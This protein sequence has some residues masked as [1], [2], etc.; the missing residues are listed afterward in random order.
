MLPLVATKI[1][2]KYVT[3]NLIIVLSIVNVKDVI[4][5]KK[6]WQVYSIKCKFY[7]KLF[8]AVLFLMIYN[9]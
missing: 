1:A 9:R 5:Y 4:I 3:V 6:H 2:Q 8:S 7:E